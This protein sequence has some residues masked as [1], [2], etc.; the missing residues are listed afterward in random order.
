MKPKWVTG[1]FFAG[2]SAALALSTIVC[3]TRTKAKT[4]FEMAYS[5]V[6]QGMTEPEVTAILGEPGASFIPKEGLYGR[7]PV[8]SRAWLGEGDGAEIIVSFDQRQRVMRKELNRPDDCSWWRRAIDFAAGL[9]SC[10]KKWDGEVRLHILPDD[11]PF[12]RVTNNG[13]RAGR[14][15]SLGAMG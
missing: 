6:Q 8:F 9:F 13:R 14:G 1:A 15:G 11:G 2:L 4:D 12:L 5:L 7:E 10:D 3:F